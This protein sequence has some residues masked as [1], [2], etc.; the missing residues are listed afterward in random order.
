M[1]DK[2]R[3]TLAVRSPKLFTL[4]VLYDANTELFGGSIDKQGTSEYQAALRKA[5]DYWNE[6]AEIIPDWKKVKDGH[7]LA[8]QLRQEKINAHS[9]VIR[10]L[11]ALGKLLFEERPSDW[12]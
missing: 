12:K 11:G 1:V 9:V 4:S 5:I 8:T 10:A 7:M 2:E 3:V 6:L